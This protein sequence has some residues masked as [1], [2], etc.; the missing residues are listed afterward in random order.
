M[1]AHRTAGIIQFW[2][3]VLLPAEVVQFSREQRNFGRSQG[4]LVGINLHTSM[5]TYKY[6][7]KVPAIKSEAKT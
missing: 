4:F 1:C 6:V 3:T 2:P 7:F 5:S